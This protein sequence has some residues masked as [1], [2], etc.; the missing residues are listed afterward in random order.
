MK[1]PLNKMK[2]TLALNLLNDDDMKENFSCNLDEM[3]NQSR[4]C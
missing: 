4:L 1:R 2:I 3:E